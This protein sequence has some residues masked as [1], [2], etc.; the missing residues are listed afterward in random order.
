[1]ALLRG[2]EKQ[3]DA[4]RKIVFAGGN[5]F[6]RAEQH[7][8]VTVVTAGVHLTIDARAVCVRVFLE[9]RQ[10]IHI[11]AQHHGAPR[12]AALDDSD[13]AGTPNAGMH[14]E[15]QMPQTVFYNTGGAVFFEAELGV[16]MQIAA[17]RN[18]VRK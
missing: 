2:L 17:H 1:V 14:V 16:H 12:L 8:H 13:N 11:G 5:Q 9:N 4:P 3:A 15:A 10:C 18:N 6:G 7:R